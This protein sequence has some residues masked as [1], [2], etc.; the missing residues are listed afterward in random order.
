MHILSRRTGRTRAFMAV[1]NRGYPTRLAAIPGRSQG[2]GMK[3]TTTGTDSVSL[4]PRW[5]VRNRR[6]SRCLG[7]CVRTSKKTPF[8]TSPRAYARTRALGEG[9]EIPIS[10]KLEHT[11]PHYRTPHVVVSVR[12]RALPGDSGSAARTPHRSE[13]ETRSMT[14]H[15]STRAPWSGTPMTVRGCRGAYHWPTFPPPGVSHTRRPTVS[16]D[17]HPTNP[18]PH[19]THPTCVRRTGTPPVT[20]PGV[21]RWGRRRAKTTLPHRNGL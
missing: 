20:P 4:S 6:H 21:E 15:H 7:R 10:S 13:S 11:T 14:H 1:D 12:R 9:K 2:S 16:T 18:P 8:H 17:D 5:G 19:T 3:E